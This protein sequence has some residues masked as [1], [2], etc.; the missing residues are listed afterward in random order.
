MIYNIRIWK[1]Y[2]KVFLL[3]H[4]AKAVPRK[5]VYVCYLVEYKIICNQTNNTTIKNVN[6]KSSIF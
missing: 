6:K 1:F 4:A 5:G 3:L 2:Q